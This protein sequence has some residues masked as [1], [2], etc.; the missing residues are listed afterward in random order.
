MCRMVA[1]LARLLQEV[2]DSTPDECTLVSDEEDCQY[3]G[4]VSLSNLRIIAIVAI[5]VASAIGVFAPEI[6]RRLG[7]SREHTLFFIVKAFGAGII[8][9]TGK[10]LTFHRLQ[11]ATY[12]V[13]LSI[14]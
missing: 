9:S 11:H 2:E 12:W 10:A 7:L 6:L 13:L 5:L 8:L 4:G 1:E 3:A 14:I